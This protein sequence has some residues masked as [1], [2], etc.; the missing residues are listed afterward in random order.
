RYD[1]E[2]TVLRINCVQPAIANLHPRDVIANGGDLPAFEMFRRNEHG[3]ICFAARAWERGGHIIFFALRG[4]HAK[5]QH[6]LSEPALFARQVRTDAQGETFFTE[7][8][9][10]AVAGAHGND[11]VVLWKMTDEATLRTDVQQRMHATVPLSVWIVAE[12]FHGYFAHAG[13]D[14]HIEHN[15]F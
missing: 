13:H 11:R 14:P 12:P 10:A 8:N 1:A 5:D 15:I 2:I 7:Q 4:F 3:E 9:V 6:V